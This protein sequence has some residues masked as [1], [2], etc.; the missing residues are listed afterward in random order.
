MGSAL[1]GAVLISVCAQILLCC[2]S[3]DT[4]GIGR[5]VRAVFF[6]CVLCLLLMPIYQA[7]TAMGIHQDDTG[8]DMSTDQ[9][10]GNLTAE[11]GETMVIEQTVKTLKQAVIQSVAVQFSI[12]VECID[13]T[14]VIDAKDHSRGDDYQYFCPT[15]RRSIWNFDGKD[16]ALSGRKIYLT[17]CE[18]M[19]L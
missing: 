14:I 12:P 5:Y 1:Y 13:A 7:F 16:R 17:E 3:N 9:T 19:V 18:V 4:R 2:F 6:A 10:T 8:F 15:Q 11:M